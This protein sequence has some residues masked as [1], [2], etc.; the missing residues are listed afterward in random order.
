M[1]NLW[2]IGGGLIIVVILVAGPF[3]RRWVNRTAA[4]AGAR[5]GQRYAEHN[6]SQANG[7]LPEKLHQLGQTVV[8]AVPEERAQ[9]I[10]TQAAA[11]NPQDYPALDDGSFGLKLTDPTDGVVRLVADGATTRVQLERF[12]EHLGSPMLMPTWN[13]F[14]EN[15]TK[16]A[17]SA[18]VTATPGPVQTYT[19]GAVVE[20]D[21]GAWT[22]NT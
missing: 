4:G 6:I 19:R 12:R 22:R 21:T 10:V 2:Y 14:R 5:A 11:T 3:V 17:A 20:G 13:T 1:D 15:I 18:G 8:L 7:T 9:A 16:A